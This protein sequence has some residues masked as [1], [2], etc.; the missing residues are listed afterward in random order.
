MNAL[1]IPYTADTVVKDSEHLL[2]PPLP[3]ENDCTLFDTTL[4]ATPRQSVELIDCHN[5]SPFTANDSL[6]ES[7]N[8]DESS[9]VKDELGL[10]LNITVSLSND[11]DVEGTDLCTD[12]DLVSQDIKAKASPSELALDIDD[13]I[14]FLSGLTLNDKGTTAVVEAC[15]SCIQTSEVGNHCQPSE[16]HSISETSNQEVITISSLPVAPDDF[17]PQTDS[18]IDGVLPDQISY[19]AEEPKLCVDENSSVP[20][21]LGE[22]SF[23]DLLETSTPNKEC[24]V[25]CDVTR[26]L[27][28]SPVLDKKVNADELAESLDSRNCVEDLDLAIEL[29][30]EASQDAREQ[31][32]TKYEKEFEEL[33]LNG[34]LPSYSDAL[35]EKSVHDACNDGQSVPPDVLNEATSCSSDLSRLAESWSIISSEEAETSVNS[36]GITC[37]VVSSDSA[38]CKLEHSNHPDLEA[39]NPENNSLAPEI[40]IAPESNFDTESS[41]NSAAVERNETSVL[42][43]KSEESNSRE[44]TNF[45][46]KEQ[47][48]D[49]KSSCDT[50]LDGKS[51]VGIVE[52]NV[53]SQ[54]CVPEEENEKPILILNKSIYLYEDITPLGQSVTSTDIVSGDC[55]LSAGSSFEKPPD[56]LNSENL[57]N[58]DGGLA[59]ESPLDDTVK[60]DVFVETRESCLHQ[61]KTHTEVEGVIFQ[62]TATDPLCTVEPEE[63]SPSVTPSALDIS[64]LLPANLDVEKALQAEAYQVIELLNLSQANPDLFGNSVLMPTSGIQSSNQ[65][66][67]NANTECASPGPE[68]N[69]ALELDDNVNPFQ[70]KSKLGHSPD[71]N[72]SLDNSLRDA[73]YC[74]DNGKNLKYDPGQHIVSSKISKGKVPIPKTSPKRKPAVQGLADEKSSPSAQD[75]LSDKRCDESCIEHNEISGEDKK[76]KSEMQ[77]VVNGSACDSSAVSQDVFKIPSLPSKGDCRAVPVSTS[78]VPA[79]V[80]I[81]LV[82]M[83][84]FFCYISF[85]LTMFEMLSH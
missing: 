2:I 53:Q 9:N 76:D 4:V 72:Q 83:V 20:G 31:E 59:K 69:C 54:N 64:G 46:D 62:E 85:L 71:K 78:D 68:P 1:L 7:Q 56:I 36:S 50:D 60:P 27:Q 24:I 41:S 52:E 65:M 12:N 10:S 18:S 33:A 63:F 40:V 15:D 82:P 6:Q 48:I 84:V 5:Q 17:P 55:N 45:D 3:L 14:A 30:P 73:E 67:D 23:P 70:T 38:S 32:L 34:A 26:P 8:A 79:P 28:S 37:A 49:I 51:G 22:T 57:C 19:V 39:V 16:F 47:V 66:A 44:S 75:T 11:T 21:F 13:C 61:D 80:S 77:K 42:A 35:T 81:G 29:P 58:N 25:D 74:T 43:T